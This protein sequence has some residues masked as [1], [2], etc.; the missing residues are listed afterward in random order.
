MENKLGAIY[1]KDVKVPHVVFERWE[2]DPQMV[3]CFTSKLGGVSTG[4]C[5]SLN[6]GFN[7]GDERKNVLENYRRVGELIGTDIEHMVLTNQVHETKIEEV[8]L[9]D[10]GNGLLRPNKW[11]NLDGIYTKD[12]NLTLVT[13]YADCVPLFFYAPK[14]GMIGMAHAGWRGT[15]NE[16]GKKMIDIWQ[17]EHNIP[18]EAIE[19]G[20][21]PSIGPCCFEV[22][23]DVAN[24]F[25]EK[26]GHQSFIKENKK[27]NKYH[28][29]LWA[30]NAYSL[31][32][33]GI[34]PNQIAKAEMCTCCENDFFFSHRKTQG[35]RGTLGA[36]MYLK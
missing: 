20:I 16:I 24:V 9:E 28:I 36:F 30:C 17:H 32:T 3:H 23:K 13:H 18:L 2:N 4:I 21:G 22:D 27:T 8:H 7:R 12:K 10:G 1:K 33:I 5:E 35:K 31:E 25:L 6:L 29:D 19:V 34:K 15:V 11:E 26:F 14:Y